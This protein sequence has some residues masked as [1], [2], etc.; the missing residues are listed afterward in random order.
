MKKVTCAMFLC[1]VLWHMLLCCA[2]WCAGLYCTVC[3]L[4]CAMWCFAV[5]CSIWAVTVLYS[6]LYSSLLCCV[7]LCCTALHFTGLYCTVC[8]YFSPMCLSEQQH[9]WHTERD[10]NNYTC[11]TGVTITVNGSQ[12]TNA[13]FNEGTTWHCLGVILRTWDCRRDSADVTPEMVR[14]DIVWAW[15]CVCETVDVTLRTWLLR[16]DDVRKW[17]RSLITARTDALGSLPQSPIT[18]S[19]RISRSCG[20]CCVPGKSSPTHVST[21][22]MTV[23][24]DVWLFRRTEM[25]VRRCRWLYCGIRVVIACVLGALAP[26]LFFLVCLFIYCFWVFFFSCHFVVCHWGASYPPFVLKGYSFRVRLCVS[27]IVVGSSYHE[28]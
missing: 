13:S 16:W 15:S 6:V 24:H 18:H 14:R 11:P 3:F 28:D 23:F 26:F 22:H 21:C 7:G 5:Q 4:C 8:W 25:I 1:A 19:Y 12:F 20:R 17:H 9:T 27:Q 2:V 10:V